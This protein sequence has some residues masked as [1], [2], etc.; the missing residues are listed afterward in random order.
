M[1]NEQLI[2]FKR[3][4]L[5]V[6]GDSVI[7]S[8]NRTRLLYSFIQELENIGYYLSLEVVEKISEEE[9]KRAYESIIPY[10]SEVYHLNHGKEFTPL[11]P[12]FPDQI[13][14]E[15][16]LNL[17]VDEG[18]DCSKD[19]NEF[20]KFNT[21]CSGIN[22]DVINRSSE[23]EIKLMTETEFNK[24]LP[25]IVSSNNSL[26]EDTKE[27]LVWLLKN[28]PDLTLPEKIPF[29]ETLCIVMKFRKDYNPR[30]INDVL[31]YGFYE[32]GLDPA[33]IK[34]KERR[35][36]KPFPR[37]TRKN[38]LNYIDKLVKSLGINKTV[39][40]AK[41]FYNF[42]TLL[43]EK[44]HWGDYRKQYPE[45]FHFFIELK[46]FRKNYKTW[47]SKVQDL[48]NKKEG[49]VEIAKFISSHPGE[50]IRKFDSLLRRSMNEGL[51]SDIM[52]IFIETNGMSNKTL[53]ELIG[54][55]DRRL[56]KS[57]RVISIKGER[58]SK[59][60]DPLPEI[61]P[62]IIETI[63]EVI[64][65]KILLNISSRV[66]DE[67]LLGKFV[68]I[69]S[70]IV[71]I[72]VP[73]SMRSQMLYVPRGTKLSI[74]K[75]KNIIRFFVHWIQEGRDEDLDLHAYF[76]DS[77][78]T[79]TANIG[80]NSKLVSSYGVHSGDVL[81][82]EG[83]C[84]EYV[85][86]DLK[87]AVSNGF[88]YV[89][90][91]VYNYKGRGFDTLPC[92]LGYCFRNSIEGGDKKWSPDRVEL[93]HPITTKGYKTA[94]MLVDMVD[95]SVTIL[96][97]DLNGLPVNTVGEPEQFQLNL[98]KFFTC[99]ISFSI[100]DI[101]QQYYISRGAEVIDYLTDEI[102]LVEKITKDDL[103]KDYTRIL[104]IIGE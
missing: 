64:K 41:L 11:F 96:D 84:A 20:L 92:W 19:Y 25:Q 43:S 67:D 85:D 89:I 71:N 91:D 104:E 49:I 15:E 34:T 75:D 26:M 4:K 58:R 61:S 95:Y 28:Y 52:D 68:Y 78:C 47:N 81:N 59:I 23:K 73:K 40:D 33:L 27:E 56:N 42:W 53:I 76:V 82:R 39:S 10:L 100:Y 30:S 21:L 22:K 29:K 13:I 31:R 74:P 65:R 97:V 98:L 88:R 38:V 6:K 66:L 93:M 7:S 101:L 16:E 69:D 9:I 1:I 17:I 50:F 45:A 102:D 8:I 57:P 99:P 80:W 62:N 103:I 32:L 87:S 54:Y 3:G 77:E 72:A 35:S 37:S 46:F 12:G 36:F 14:T 44:L 2:A 55:Y 48:Y 83:N 86:I 60:L 63:Q 24:I 79:K 90:M 51:E 5:L 18:T 70:E 94:A